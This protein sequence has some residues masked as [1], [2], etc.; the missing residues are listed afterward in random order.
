MAP[1]IIWTSWRV[2]THISHKLKIQ[3]RLCRRLLRRRVVGAG[4]GVGVGMCFCCHRCRCLLGLVLTSASG[5]SHSVKMT[6]NSTTSVSL[7]ILPLPSM[8][9]GIGG[10]EFLTLTILNRTLILPNA[11]AQPSSCPILTM[12][13]CMTTTTTTLATAT[14][15]Y[16]SNIT[17]TFTSPKTKRGAN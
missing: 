10:G 17:A 5:S 7:F 14:A 3:G 6:T 1:F 8:T 15:S 9:P 16:L 13:A 11:I 2:R 4:V 12:N